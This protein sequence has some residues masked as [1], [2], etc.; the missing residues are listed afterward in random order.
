M[1]HG[2]EAHSGKR[3]LSLCV[4][5]TCI[6]TDSSKPLERWSFGSSPLILGSELLHPRKE[7]AKCQ[8]FH[9]DSKDQAP[10]RILPTGPKLSLSWPYIT[11]PGRFGDN[12]LGFVPIPYWEPSEEFQ[13]SARF[14]P[15]GS[16]RI[17]GAILLSSSLFARPKSDRI[18]RLEDAAGRHCPVD[19]HDCRGST[20]HHGPRQSAGLGPARFPILRVWW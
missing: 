4:S 20:S 18:L 13:N 8:S 15:T 9:N 7:I 10:C 14:D 6:N 17:A 1:P 3:P 16:T 11:S 5:T 2:A 12:F 19:R